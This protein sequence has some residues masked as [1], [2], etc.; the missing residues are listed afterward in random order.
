MEKTEI[1]LERLLTATTMSKRLL[2][3]IAITVLATSI[4]SVSLIRKAYAAPPVVALGAALTKTAD[5]TAPFISIDPN[6]SNG[7][8]A[9]LDTTS[10]TFD[11]NMNTLDASPHQLSGVT[12][13]ATLTSTSADVAW[14]LNSLPSACGT[15]TLSVDGKTM[16]CVVSG[17][18]STGTTLNVSGAWFGKSSVPNGTDVTAQFTVSATMTPDASLGTNP[19][20]QASG[21]DTVEVVSEAGDY[22]VRKQKGPITILRDG[23]GDP[24]YIQVDWGVQTE[25][26]SP[27]VGQVKGLNAGAFSTLS[28]DDKLATG[29]SSQLPVNS[30]GELVGC[31]PVTSDQQYLPNS[32]S[33]TLGDILAVQNSGSW[34]CTQSGGVGTD[35]DIS[36]TGID[37]SPDW[38]PYGKSTNRTSYWAYNSG[39]SNSIYN[40]PAGLHNQA[41]VAT[42]VVRIKYPF[43]TILDFDQ[44]AGDRDVRANFISWCNDI[45]DAAVTG[46]S[47]GVDDVSN[48]QNCVVF[49][50]LTGTGPWT[51]KYFTEYGGRVGSG[52]EAD[53]GLTQ[54]ALGPGDSDNYVAPGMNFAQAQVADVNTTSAYGLEDWTSCD[55]ID[56]TKYNFI[57]HSAPSLPSGA[58]GSSHSWYSWYKVGTPDPSFPV[59]GDSD[60]VV[61]YASTGTT[62][63][64]S[65]QQRTVNCDSGSLT[66]VEDPSTHPGGLANVNL[67]RVRILKALPP[68]MTITTYQSLRA[69]TGLAENTKM[70][71]FNRYKA[72][73]IN[74]GAW[75]GSNPTCIPENDIWNASSGLYSCIALADRAIVVQPTAII[76]KYDSS[77]AVDVAA[78]VSLGGT[79]TYNIKAGMSF[80]VDVAIGGV[81]IYDVMP[82]GMVYQSA[83]LTPSAVITDC[84][85]VANFACI[86]NPAARTNYGYTTL[87]WDR[88]DF[89]F[90]QSGSPETPATDYTLF[91]NFQVTTRIA[92]YIPNAAYLQN[93]AWIDAEEGLQDLP[94]TLPFRTTGTAYHY[95]PT[96]GPYDDDWVQ[97]ATAQSFNIEKYISDT[98]IDLDGTLGFTLAFGNL[99]GSAKV[100]D[101]IDIFPYDDDGRSPVSDVDGGYSLTMAQETFSTG[102]ISKIYVTSDDPATLSDDPND[103]SNPAA[104][105]GK[106]SCEFSQLGTSGCPDAD[107]VTAIRIKTVSMT[108]GQY[109]LFHFELETNDND[110]EEVYTNSWQARATALAL[111]VLSSDVSAVTPSCLNLGN[112]VF[113]D[114]NG[115]G[116]YDSGDTGI[117]GVVLNLYSVGIDGDIGGGD[118]V[119][120]KTTTTD[121]DGRWLVQCVAPGDYYIELDSSNFDSGGP[122]HDFI[123]AP[124]GSDDPTDDVDEDDQQD[125]IVDGSRFRTNI[126]S[127]SYL[128]NPT[129]ETGGHTGSDANDNLTIDLG[130][131]IDPA[132]VPTTTTVPPTAVPTSTVVPAP[133]TS[134]SGELANTGIS[135]ALLLIDIAAVIG[136]GFLLQLTM[137][138]RRKSRQASSS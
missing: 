45:G 131:V 86:A 113:N 5:G 84:N 69:K 58:S 72:S 64:T 51:A 28:L 138:R 8:V 106:W 11:V 50:Y 74:S 63:S 78:S 18:F 104:G 30:E 94:A 36:A 60:V 127:V 4:C 111:P 44:T 25:V 103:S 35:I 62:F 81:H 92:S 132:S 80:N 117:E 102:L 21:T 39:T 100:M 38:F 126:L 42:Q 65:S 130:L 49:N 33:L 48:N 134:I 34:T 93:K 40:S 46:G 115:N 125:L 96:S 121:S 82:P 114:V 68:G 29:D 13:V 118:D 77:P 32:S 19:T 105:T 57:E 61:E 71:N 119:L 88:G 1:S 67:V 14:M 22:E 85:A 116:K 53:L 123:E 10:Y 59:I 3:L 87:R 128:N 47:S 89:T 55:A 98:S 2:A 124:E 95:D 137:L 24:E 52:P 101:G 91:G 23:V 75:Y 135:N 112:L 70:F 99:T 109:G 108:A 9:S 15:K 12:I 122:L 6:A 20:P 43:Q 129:G 83:T 31:L 26:K 17:T 54:G 97:I 41:P 27:E 133:R 16:T 76:Q 37:W 110:G 7:L 120:S 90:D 136:V 107:E 73:N 66:W 79:W 56:Q